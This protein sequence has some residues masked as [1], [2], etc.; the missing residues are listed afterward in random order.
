MQTSEERVIKQQHFNRLSR[1]SRTHILKYKSIGQI[2]R[3]VKVFLAFR[4]RT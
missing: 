3:V 2:K 1:N 4:I